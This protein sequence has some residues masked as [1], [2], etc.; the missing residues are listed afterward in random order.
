MLPKPPSWWE[1]LAVPPQEPLRASALWALIFVTSGLIDWLLEQIIDP[2]LLFNRECTVG[3]VQYVLE[4]GGAT[5]KF[6][7]G[8]SLRPTTNVLQA[9]YDL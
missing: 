8:P 4:I 9:I 5:P 7:G 6:L 3:V 2:P 1:E